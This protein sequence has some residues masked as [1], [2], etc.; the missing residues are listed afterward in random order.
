M[1]KLNKILLGSVLI[2]LLLTLVIIVIDPLVSDVSLMPDTGPKHYYWQLADRNALNMLIVWTMF[3]LQ[4]YGN[5]HFI[6]IR[7]QDKRREFTSVN[8]QILLFNL[9]FIIIHFIQSIFGYDGLAQDV[10]VFSS[11]YSVILVLVMIILIQVPRRGIIFGKKLKIDK[12]AMSILYRIHGFLFT[13]AIVYTFWFH[14]TIY[15][16][17]HLF[18]FF[19]MFLLFIQIGFFKTKI[20]TNPKW[21]VGLEVLVAFHGA[22]VAYFVQNSSLWSMFLFGFGFIFFATQIYGLTTNK[23]IIRACQIGFLSVVGIYYGT[24][25]ITDIHQ[26]LW[27]P[28]VE[29][30]HVLI[31]Y[32]I[33]VILTQIS[34][35]KLKR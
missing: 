22:S 19:Y 15:T 6:R 28:I 4:L 13:F 21:I 20:H 10:S 16:I 17:G 30:G 26:V 35:K 14:P 3:G 32:G 11:Q 2:A 24:H 5:I 9:L 1:S 31:M 34:K 33:I 25:Q 23:T 18:G 27:I 29:Y 8:L 7:Q 12:Q